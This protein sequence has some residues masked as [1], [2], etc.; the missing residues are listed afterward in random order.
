MERFTKE[1]RISVTDIVTQGK[2]T[3]SQKRAMLMKAGISRTA[4][5][6]IELLYDVCKSDI[7]G[8]YVPYTDVTVDEEWELIPF[9]LKKQ[10][11]TLYDTFLPYLQEIK[12]V[13]ELATLCGVTS[14]LLIRPLMLGKRHE[15]YR[16]GICFEVVR[17]SKRS[18][19]LATGGRYLISYT[20]LEKVV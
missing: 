15:L 18:D 19:I 1:Q 5:D 8:H 7:K 16:N 4:I 14:Q 12:K 11:P 10:F 13:Q 9:R 17:R 2:P 6:E 3:I 20:I